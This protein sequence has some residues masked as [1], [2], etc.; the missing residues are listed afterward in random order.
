MA[1]IIIMTEYYT[2][3]IRIGRNK[4]NFGNIEDRLDEEINRLYNSK[5]VIKESISITPIINTHEGLRLVS[6]YWIV[7]VY[8]C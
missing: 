5:K 8:T 1:R 4:N 3:T 7:Y 2:K 6:E